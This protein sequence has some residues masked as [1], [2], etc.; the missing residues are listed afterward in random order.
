M[1]TFRVIGNFLYNKRRASLFVFAMTKKTRTVLFLGISALFLLVAPIII[2]YS[3]GYRFDF[4]KKTVVQTGG[5]VVKAIPKEAEVSLDGRKKKKTDFIFGQAFFGDILP[6]PHRVRV[7]K[8]GYIAWEKEL[9]VKEKQLTQAYSIF[10]FPKNPGWNIVQEDLQDVW[11]SPRGKRIVVEKKIENSPLEIKNPQNFETL[12]TI[13]P[14]ETFA[15]KKIKNIL[16]PEDENTILFTTEGSIPQFFFVRENGSV[17]RLP[18]Q[19]KNLVET[20]FHPALPSKLFLLYEQKKGVINVEEYDLE[21]KKT[22]IV[23]QGIRAFAMNNDGLFWITKEGNL[24]VGNFSGTA[25]SILTKEPIPLDDKEKV[26]LFISDSSSRNGI[27]L[28]KNTTLFSFNPSQERFEKIAD[29]FS[30]IVFSPDRKMAAYY[31]PYEIWIFSIEPQTD[32]PQKEA[33]ANTFLTRIGEPIVSLQWI[34]SRYLFF[35][36]A[37]QIKIAEIDDRDG[38]N[39]VTIPTPAPFK[40]I[41][42]NPLNKKFYLFSEG[43]IFIS[44]QK[45]AP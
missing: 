40:E 29:S 37:S 25:K 33:R 21:Q 39:I 1:S 31:T 28:G 24:I 44:D 7:S 22:S 35:R 20:L 4:K 45:F 11:F 36:T 8:E 13:F 16:W 2:F 6:G 9:E 42:F 12:I 17:Q 19:T 26:T 32:Q 27:F 18:L 3:Q 5:I 14:E 23:L 34:S 10:L 38:L 43:K 15:G 41:F 30:R